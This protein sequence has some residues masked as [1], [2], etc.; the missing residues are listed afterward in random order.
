MRHYQTRHPGPNTLANHYR[1]WSRADLTRLCWEVDN[2]RAYSDCVARL[3]ILFG[4]TPKAIHS[5]LRRQGIR[6]KAAP[7]Y[8]TLRDASRLIGVSDASLL[9]LANAGRFVKNLLPHTRPQAHRILQD[10]LWTWMEDMRSWHIW[11]P[12]NIQDLA[13]REH[14]SE[15]RRDWLTAREAARLL[16][17][18]TERIHAMRRLGYLPGVRPVRRCAWFRRADVETIRR[19]KLVGCSYVFV[20]HP[21]TVQRLARAAAAAVGAVLC[22]R[23]PVLCDRPQPAQPA[24]TTEAACGH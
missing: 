15:L 22:D 5:I 7:G 20:P 9:T 18:S 2:L 21:R 8:L 3:A 17:V 23:P 13:W 1:R 14:S 11:R 6:I 16:Y 4:R 19:T 24:P 12:E 10:D